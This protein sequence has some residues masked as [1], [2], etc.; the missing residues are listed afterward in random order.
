MASDCPTHT[1]ST[2]G[3]RPKRTASGKPP[4]RSGAKKRAPKNPVPT[5]ANKMARLSSLVDDMIEPSVRK[6]GFVLSRLVSNWRHIAGDI[7]DWCKPVELKLD[8]NTHKDGVLKLSITSGRGPQAQSMAPQIID[9][10]NAAFGYAA[11]SRITLIQTMSN[12]GGPN[13]GGPNAG[14]HEFSPFGQSQDDLTEHAKSK[15]QEKNDVWTLDEKLANIKS[16]E[17]RAALRRLGTPI[18]KPDQ[19]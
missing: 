5:R 6:R 1:G 11:V 14:P 3:N 16:P 2:Q 12:A 7:A 8:K 18:D 10:V 4:A 19:S 15:P 17:L 9:R 13:A